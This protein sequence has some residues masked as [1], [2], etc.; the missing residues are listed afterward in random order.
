MTEGFGGT[1]RWR[2][3]AAKWSMIKESMMVKVLFAGTPFVGVPALGGLA[4][5]A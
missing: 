3:A 2:A 4:G 1:S 5:Y